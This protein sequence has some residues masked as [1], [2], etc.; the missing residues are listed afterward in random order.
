[1]GGLNFIGSN[2]D[3]ADGKESQRYDFDYTDPEKDKSNT[4]RLKPRTSFFGRHKKS[5]TSAVEEP[6][7]AEEA[8]FVD[9]QQVRK[10]KYKPTNTQYQPQKAGSQTTSAST[11]V[12]APTRSTTQSSVQPTFAQV[13]RTVNPTEPISQAPMP[14]SQSVQPPVAP[15]GS[16]I[17]PNQGQAPKQTLSHSQ[18]L[19]IAP[20]KSPAV[21]SPEVTPVAP[22]QST[23]TA[24]PT[25]PQPTV[26]PAVSNTGALP[27]TSSM[28]TKAP[29]S[30]A[31]P[32]VP[33]GERP[34]NIP[35]PPPP[36]VHAAPVPMTAK[37]TTIAAPAMQN[38]Q[39]SGHQKMY[40]TGTQ[41]RQDSIIQQPVVTPTSAPAIQTPELQP[42]QNPNLPHLTSVPQ[43]RPQQTIKQI[44]P[45][46][47]EAPA[48]PV[49]KSV[50]PTPPTIPE[51]P[52]SQRTQ[53]AGLPR[54]VSTHIESGMPASA[55]N[56]NT[57]MPQIGTVFA[58]NVESI[59]GEKT[60]PE[61]IS[62]KF[63]AVNLLPADFLKDL[64]PASKIVGLI[65]V[66]LI[67][68]TVLGLIYGIMVGYQSYFIIQTKNNQLEINR[69]ETEILTYVPLQNEI[70]SANLQLQSVSTLLARHIYWSNIFAMLEKYTLPNV[71]YQNFSGSTSGLITLQALTTDFSSISQQ[72]HI[73]NEE[74]SFVQSATST[75][76]S[77]SDVVVEEDTET[78]TEPTNN[79]SDIV[80]FTINLH[81]DPAIFLY[82]ANANLNGN[83]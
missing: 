26:F 21:T 20:Q 58:Q 18:I 19:P 62:G 39:Q 17:S 28:I 55:H 49:H 79:S 15:V 54:S 69:L 41:V 42:L 8:K 65:K 83:N 44:V 2:N 31:Q 38:I 16:T 1:M 48:P 77:R 22:L 9:K 53:P 47:P 73:L 10:G 74:A 43:P 57:H 37:T 61:L 32:V 78:S 68:S 13:N 52:S 63:L 82:Q 67:S 33:S 60:D 40:D 46:I 80:A 76:A 5:N 23:S 6:K 50:V 24:A 35:T 34:C 59:H 11:T 29:L 70:N 51:A 72:I 27:T 14:V 25:A 71:T 81:L 3:D 4:G 7:K 64:T 66:A 56:A 36:P 12:Y 45:K 75:S 30:K